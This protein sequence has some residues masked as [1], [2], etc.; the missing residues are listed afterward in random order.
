[1]LESVSYDSAGGFGAR[2][3][4]RYSNRKLYDTKSSRYVTL[5]QIA[6]MVRSGEEVQII[7]NRTKEDKTEVTLALI[8]SEELKNS[9]GGIPLDT[10]KALIRHDSSPPP[11]GEQRTFAGARLL[12]LALPRALHVAEVVGV[13]GVKVAGRE[14]GNEDERFARGTDEFEAEGQEYSMNDLSKERPE[15]GRGL[16]QEQGRAEQAQVEQVQLQ[17]VQL[18]QVQVQQ[19]ALQG[20]VQRLD[21]RVAELEQRLSKRQE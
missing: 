4:K 2:V 5:L 7:D 11:S 13:P 14:P 18:Q 20:Q 15:G 1:M 21:E 12:G 16:S 8:I 10:L 17:Q 6:Q 19:R 9:P 3:I